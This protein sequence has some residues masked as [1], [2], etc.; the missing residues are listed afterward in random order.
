MIT[1]EELVAREFYYS[2]SALI[3]ELSKIETFWEDLQPLLEGQDEDGDPVE[4]YEHWIVSDWMAA[5]LKEK[6]EAVLQDFLGLTIYGRTT[7]GQALYMDRVITLICE[8][9][10]HA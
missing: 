1:P 4:I 8:D 5:R 6:G 9:I 3:Y 2:A 7:T 10:N